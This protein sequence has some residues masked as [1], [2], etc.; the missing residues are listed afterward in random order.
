MDLMNL[1]ALVKYGDTKFITLVKNSEIYMGQRI[2]YIYII[3]LYLY[4]LLHHG[5][6]G[7]FIEIV[8]Q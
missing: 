7:G 2:S 6:G 3:G 1:L 4:I 5:G 8:N